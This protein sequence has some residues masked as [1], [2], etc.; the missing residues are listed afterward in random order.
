VS[1]TRG[2]PARSAA[3]PGGAGAAP[4]A[5]LRWRAGGNRS[6]ACRRAR[7]RARAR[8]R[9]APCAEVSVVGATSTSARDRPRG[10]CRDRRR[11]DTTIVPAPRAAAGLAGGHAARARTWTRVCS[12]RR[13][14]QRMPPPLPLLQSPVRRPPPSPIPLRPMPV[15]KAPTTDARTAAKAGA[16]ARPAPDILHRQG[17]PPRRSRAMLRRSR[18]T[19]QPAA[20]ARSPVRASSSH[21]A[22]QER[23]LRQRV[24]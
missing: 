8:R 2:R 5:A 21:S 23:V 7:D 13:S 4:R 22:F 12:P 17:G 6:A 15:T 18:A 10:W 24:F 11:P 3:S 9:S 1:L 16:R 19:P 20:G 14:A